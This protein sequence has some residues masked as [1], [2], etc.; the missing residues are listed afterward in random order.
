MISHVKPSL[1]QGQHI[2]IYPNGT[3]VR[4]SNGLEDVVARPTIH[5]LQRPVVLILSDFGHK[6]SPHELDLSSKLGVTIVD[7]GTHE[8]RLATV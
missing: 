3:P 2:N 6:V 7:C 5:N 4:L 1:S 8:Q